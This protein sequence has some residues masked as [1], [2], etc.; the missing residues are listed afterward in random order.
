MTN[1]E[2]M[3]YFKIPKSTFYDWLKRDDYRK[4]IIIHLQKT[5]IKK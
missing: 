5:N 4:K 2:I 1:K 3:D